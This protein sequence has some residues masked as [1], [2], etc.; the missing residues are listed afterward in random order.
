MN[1]NRLIYSYYKFLIFLD[2][3]ILVLF[4]VVAKKANGA[5][6]YVGDKYYSLKN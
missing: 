6:I 5:I 2:I 3:F 1:F 4:V